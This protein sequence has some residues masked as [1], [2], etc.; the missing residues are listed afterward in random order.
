MKISPVQLVGP[1]WDCWPAVGD[2]R[3]GRGSEIGAR[4]ATNRVFIN[5]IRINLEIHINRTLPVNIWDIYLK[6]G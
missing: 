3:A 2:R 1:L 6:S 5:N 4:T